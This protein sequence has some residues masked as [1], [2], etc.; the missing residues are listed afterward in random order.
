VSYLDSNFYCAIS[1][2]LAE[3]QSQENGKRSKLLMST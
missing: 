3:S 2:F 1:I